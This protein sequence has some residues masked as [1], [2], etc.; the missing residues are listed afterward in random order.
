MPRYEINGNNLEIYFEGKPSAEIRSQMKAIGIWWNPDKECWSRDNNPERLALAKRLCG[1]QA[2]PITPVAHEI[3]RP[4]QTE[5]Q[6]GN[7]GLR[8]KIRDIVNSTQTDQEHWEK[9]LKDFVNARLTE[10]NAGHN[11][12]AVGGAQENVW[13]DCFE[14]IKN[15]LGSLPS[16]LQEFE[17]IFEYV[18]PGC[19]YERPDVI[20]LTDTRVII[21]EFKKK[22]APQIDDNKDDVAQ[23]IRYR[24]WTENHHQVTKEHE[25][26]VSGYLICTPDDA[27]GGMLRSVEILNKSSFE[28]AL[29]NEL[30]T[31]SICE[32]ADAWINSVKTEMPDMLAAIGTLYAEH[33]IPYM[34]DVNGRCLNKVNS[35][36]SK[37]KNEHRKYLILISGVPGAGKTA[38]GQ[39]VVFE[40]NKEGVANARYLSGNGP[41]V[42]VL[43]DEINRAAGNPHAGENA[44]GGMKEFK[45]DFFDSVRGAN[46]NIPEQSI[47][48]FDEAQRAWDTEKL[49]RGFSEPEGLLRVGEKISAVRGYAVVIG[50]YG[51]GQVIYTGEETGMPLW[52][53]AVRNHEDW[54]VILPENLSSLMGENV[55]KVV[56]QDLFLPVS[57]RADFV[58]CSKWVESVV[59]RQR[60][61]VGSEAD[62]LKALQNTSMQIL[63]TRDFN[64][65]RAHV[66]RLDRDHPNWKYG[67]LISNFEDAKVLTAMTGW[68]LGYGR[69]N[70]EVRNGGY[71]EWFHEGCKKLDKACS[72]YGNQGLELDCPIVIFGGDY[73]MNDGNWKVGGYT[74]ENQ[75]ENY[76]DPDTIVENNY[77]VMLTR[78]RRQ[79]II[80]VPE[81]QSLNETYQY[82]LD[83]GVDILNA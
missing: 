72:V 24:E 32:F 50:L 20:L 12:E 5:A 68:T 21:L 40:Q 3:Q 51:N 54:T 14:F 57:L 11:G 69:K 49:G 58:D 43:Q 78:A 63:L 62:E 64:K 76:D 7:Y 73:V 4:A 29:E 48:I 37:A 28:Q 77:R 31:A 46:T 59:T 15:N 18:M 47:L 2:A 22:R 56:D 34:S 39:G 75:R 36:I 41:L 70:N 61:G 26:R 1:E 42:E 55:N 23:L 83:M 71:G 9:Q 13:F 65:I 27:Q 74:Y 80:F 38:V 45:A 35:Y 60:D 52:E 53:E 25:M 33:R 16:V 6:V 19:V 81:H 10:D 30:Q 44:I 67:L 79:M 8:L 82:F 17:L 66:R